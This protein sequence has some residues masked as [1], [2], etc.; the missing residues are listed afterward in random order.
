MSGK[1]WQITP[2]AAAVLPVP[3][4]E[5]VFGLNDCTLQEITFWVW[6]FRCG[7]VIGLVDTGLPLADDL[8]SLNEANQAL[9][10][11]SVFSQVR[12]LSEILQQQGISGEDIS[13]VLISQWITY[14]TGGL[15]RENFPRAH[16][17]CAW[18][19]MQEFLTAT[20]GHPPREFYLTK[21]SWAFVRELLVEN[22]L[23][24]VQGPLEVE[25][26]VTIEPTGGH[27]PGSA[28]VKIR[29]DR[30][31][32]GILE[33]AFIQENILRGVPIGIAENAAECRSAILS[34]R[35]ECDLVIAG[36]EPSALQLLSDFMASSH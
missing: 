8:S 14:S 28:G 1:V 5:C 2:V 30:G 6:I 16:V 11:Q 9:D 3:R 20:P 4:W 29:T 33:T 17:Y 24:F 23:T 36:H 19:G 18:G 26:G 27:H 12:P 31:L 15:S 32:V 34:Y 21:D 25:C 35:Q 7:D 13:F 10:S 22:R